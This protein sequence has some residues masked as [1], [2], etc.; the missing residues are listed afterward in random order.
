MIAVNRRARQK[1]LLG[2]LRFF[3]SL[4]HLNRIISKFWEKGSGPLI[5]T[6]LPFIGNFASKRDGAVN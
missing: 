4:S 6:P 3:Y 5:N 2:N 1:F